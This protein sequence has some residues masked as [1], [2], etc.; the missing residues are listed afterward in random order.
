MFFGGTAAGLLLNEV[1]LEIDF[2]GL[3]REIPD[4][5]VPREHS[6]EHNTTIHEALDTS[7]ISNATVVSMNSTL[8]EH[9]PDS[10]SI[11]S[12]SSEHRESGA[13]SGVPYGTNNNVLFR[14]LTTTP[15]SQDASS[16]GSGSQHSREDGSGDHHN[17]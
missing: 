9:K 12:H 11:N 4:M 10:S 17:L 3:E 6:R 8:S 13:I 5:P 14:G 16:T 2:A 7:N 15:N 1:I